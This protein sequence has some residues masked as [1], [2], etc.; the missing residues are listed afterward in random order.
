M[1][2]VGSIEKMGANLPLN[3]NVDAFNMKCHEIMRAVFVTNH[4]DTHTD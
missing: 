3:F 2:F 1:I 4:S